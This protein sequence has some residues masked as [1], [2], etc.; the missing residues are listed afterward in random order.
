MLIHRRLAL[1]A[2]AAPLS[3]AL[4]PRPC[5]RH[6]RMSATDGGPSFRAWDEGAV[7]PG[8]DDA[9]AVDAAEQADGFVDDV[10]E[11]EAEVAQTRREAAA[12]AP[13]D[14][15]PRDALLDSLRNR[16]DAEGGSLNFKLRTD[17]ERA[18]GRALDGA[19]RAADTVRDAL[20]LDGQKARRGADPLDLANW[21]LTVGAFAVIL[22]I[23]FVTAANTP[24]GAGLD[25]KNYEWGQQSGT[26]DGWDLLR[27]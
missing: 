13:N 16:L 6:I 4:V 2:L 3:G 27:R 7:P 1:V 21:R 15:V 25:Q 20:D 24:S 12:G 26:A 10:A 19:R 5:I 23:A 9:A 22:V 17:A 18:S 8:Y 14:D 11:L